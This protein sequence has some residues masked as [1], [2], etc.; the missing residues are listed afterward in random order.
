[1]LLRSMLLLSA[2]AYAQAPAPQQITLS[3]CEGTHCD[4]IWALQ[5]HDGTGTWTSGAR[6][7]FVIT[8]LTQ[9]S[10]VLRRT[11][12]DGTSPGLTAMYKGRI[13][14]NY[15]SG[16]VT[17]YWDHVSSWPNHQRTAKWS[18]VIKYGSLASWTAA[19]L[20]RTETTMAAPRTASDTQKFNLSGVWHP[21]TAEGEAS[22]NIK[23]AQN[24]EDIS[25]GLESADSEAM[26]HGKYASNLKV[27]GQGP[28]M[29]PDTHKTQLAEMDLIIT[30]PD[31]IRFEDPT[32]RQKP[33]LLVRASSPVV[34]DA[35]CDAGNSSHT[36]VQSAYQSGVA[37]F[38]KN[39]YRIAACWFSIGAD[40]GHGPSE[41]FLSLLMYQGTGVQQD[42]PRA[43]A[44]AKQSAGQDFSPAELLLSDMYKSGKGTAPDPVQ[45]AF[46]LGKARLSQQAA[47]LGVTSDMMVNGLSVASGMI[48]SMLDFNLGMTP[49]SCFSHDV[50]G[51]K[52]P[53]K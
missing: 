7:K 35:A 22:V 14:G 45:A 19:T 4:G 46:W 1:M 48:G 33:A 38:N 43:F 23:V 12:T 3:E 2:C 31:H 20:K 16:E 36:P 41:G 34:D 15:I 6:A 13:D 18:A 29:D 10:I 26:F 32:H 42:Y 27:V 21:V 52:T 47:S 39:N 9:D 53:C 51:N 25:I 8:E 5:G 49:S 40:K 24:G 28:V 44:L 11:D 30:D 17:W 37:A 50:L